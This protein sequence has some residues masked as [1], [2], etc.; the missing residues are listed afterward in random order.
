MVSQRN[1]SS[2]LYIN[3]DCETFVGER[4]QAAPP[5]HSASAY[6]ESIPTFYQWELYAKHRNMLRENVRCTYE[7][8][9][10]AIWLRN[11]EAN[12][13]G[14]IECQSWARQSSK[15]SSRATLSR[16]VQLFSP[17]YFIVKYHFILV[18]LCL[19]MGCLS[20]I[21]PSQR[22]DTLVHIVI[23]SPAFLRIIFLRAS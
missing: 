7:T 18:V 9:M 10:T 19:T 22:M 5:A 13:G 1:R 23:I 4:K 8:F 6:S 16:T 21:P 20:A 15:E 3:V 17:S 2:F 11:E 14:I 12:R